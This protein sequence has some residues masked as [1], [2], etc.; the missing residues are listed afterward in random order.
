MSTPSWEERHF[1]RRGSHISFWLQMRLAR[2]IEAGDTIEA[3]VTDAILDD[4]TSYADE[5]L[6]L[7]LTREEFL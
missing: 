2:A 7:P 4:Y 3:E 1:P 5:G 6:P